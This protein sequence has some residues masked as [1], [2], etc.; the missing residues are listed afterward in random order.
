MQI[1]TSRF[2]PVE[3]EPGDV[4]HFAGGLPGLN[5][6]SEWV[7]LGDSEN[8]CL[9]WL[10]SVTNTETALAVVSPRRFISDYQARIARSD[11]AALGLSD[12]QQAHVLVVVSVSDRVTLNLKAPLIINFEQRIGRQVITTA[13]QPLQYDLAA[14]AKSTK[15]AA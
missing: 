11:L 3:I 7:L 4:I 5:G 12:P 14:S 13:D 15:R 2:G 6:G 8:E 10:Q 9:G 1:H